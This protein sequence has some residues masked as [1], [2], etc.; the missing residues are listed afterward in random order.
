MYALPSVARALGATRRCP[1]PL[2]ST[3][4]LVAALLTAGPAQALSLEVL[5]RL[6]LERLLQL[7]FSRAPGV[8]GAPG[9]QPR[10]PENRHAR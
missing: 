2:A 6:P 4:L 7:E 10:A 5:L 1:R 3:L 9:E 8:P